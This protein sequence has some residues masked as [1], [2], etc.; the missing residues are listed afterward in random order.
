MAQD[1]SVGL[2]RLAACQ[3]TSNSIEFG[4]FN[5]LSRVR[6]LFGLGLHATLA[7]FEMVGLRR[8]H[9]RNHAEPLLRHL[10]PKGL[11]VGFV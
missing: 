7:G 8:F 4:L 1:G 11:F 6:L 2:G 3:E 10:L 9:L 5:S